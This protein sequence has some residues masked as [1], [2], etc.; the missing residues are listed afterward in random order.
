[1]LIGTLPPVSNRADWIDCIQITDSEAETEESALI[2]LTGVTI[3]IAIY[4]EDG[5]QRA[6]ATTDAGTVIVVDM[7][8]VQFTFP[9]STMTA[10]SAGTYQVGATFELEDETVQILIGSLPVMDGWVPV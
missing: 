1:M 9:R 7:G 5:C 4:D 8:V 2:D 6:S 10:L 3:I